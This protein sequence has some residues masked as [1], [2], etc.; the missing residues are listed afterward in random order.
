MKKQFIISIA[1]LALLSCISCSTTNA[2]YPLGSK[3]KKKY[4]HTLNEM[5]AGYDRFVPVLFPQLDSLD[6]KQW[7]APSPNFNIRTPVLVI[8]HHTA[9]RNCRQ[10]LRTLT[11]P[12]TN[13]RVSAN[14][15]ICKNGTVY[16]LVNERY[17]AW[18]AGVSKWGNIQ[19]INSISLGIELDN[20]GHEP[21]PYAQIRSLLIVLNSIKTRYH[22]PQGNF[23]GHADV[24][25]TRKQ[26]PSVYFPWGKLAKNGFGFWRDSLLAKPPAHFNYMTGLRLIGY[27]TRDTT[28]AKIAFKRHFIQNDI[29][30]KLNKF[31]KKVLYDI[32]LKYDK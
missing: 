14:Y 15:L 26:D 9:G 30:P 29:S 23:I 28:A 12:F 31:D 27:D 19:N 10:A 5:S 11:N 18:Q 21:F 17:R 16:Q 22:I 13:R 3:A 4:K 1:I 20:N 8:I 2:L 7:K 6:V 32:F 25:P 24:A